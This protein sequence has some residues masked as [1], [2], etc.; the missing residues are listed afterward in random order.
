MELN[1]PDS[2]MP[3]AQHGNA[4]PR[5]LRGDRLALYVELRYERREIEVAYAAA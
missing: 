3:N 2:G 4:G 5:P 1:V